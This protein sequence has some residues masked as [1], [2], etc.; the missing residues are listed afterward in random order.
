MGSPTLQP[1]MLGGG[2]LAARGGG[3]GGLTLWGGAG[4][5]V[6][7]AMSSFISLKRS[8]VLLSEKEF[9]LYNCV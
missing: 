4:D 6:N 1:Q 5:W 2:G 8:Y 3:S 9:K 7:L